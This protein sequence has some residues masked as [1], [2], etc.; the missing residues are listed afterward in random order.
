MMDAFQKQ[1]LAPASRLGAQSVLIVEDDKR[2]MQ[3]LA[4]AMEARGW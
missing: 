1:C 4:R 2:L 3:C